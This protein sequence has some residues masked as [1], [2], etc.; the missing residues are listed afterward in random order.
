M[1]TRFAIFL[2]LELI[3]VF[4]VMAIFR[5]IESRF[6][7]GMVAGGIFIALG[8]SIF[9]Y[10]L[11]TPPFRR[12]ATFLVGSFYLFFSAFPLLVSRGLNADME[13][14]DLYVWGMA[15][16]VFHRVSTAIY[17]VLLVATFVDGGM[18]LWRARMVRGREA[19]GSGRSGD[20][21]R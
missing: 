20:S 18:S 4:A 12:S 16:P 19:S 7:A 8:L 17:M 5:W 3:V 1:W 15:G 14:R 9:V 11:K 21:S 10:G 2:F 13:F 6:A